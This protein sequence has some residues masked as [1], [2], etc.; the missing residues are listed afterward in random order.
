MDLNTPDNAVIKLIDKIV[1]NVGKKNIN[2]RLWR[3]APKQHLDEKTKRR[4]R[5]MAFE[6]LLFKK[7]LGAFLIPESERILSVEQRLGVIGLM[8][9]YNGLASKAE[10]LEKLT[11]Q[12]GKSFM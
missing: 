9:R 5:A 11:S 10:R 12:L 7:H 3:H 2:K 6:I 4:Q 8:F 1:E